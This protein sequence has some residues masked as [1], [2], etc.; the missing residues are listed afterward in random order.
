[1]YC[2]KCGHELFVMHGYGLCDQCHEAIPLN[3]EPDRRLKRMVRI[4]NGL[5]DN[6]N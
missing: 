3:D 4:M 5:E 1:M 2:P 6:A